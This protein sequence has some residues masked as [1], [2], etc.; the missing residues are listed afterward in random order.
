MVSTNNLQNMMTAPMRRVR[1]IHM[2]GIGG[3]GMAGIAE[4]LLNLGYEVSGTD[5]KESAATERL[6][7]LGAK[8]YF[9]HRAE[10]AHNVDAVVVSTAVKA[11]NPELEYA[12]VNFPS[13]IMFVMRHD[14]RGKTEEPI[15]TPS[16]A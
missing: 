12:R 5:L 3:S 4:V 7:E 10:N 6:T 15:H 2:L 14:M 1:R 16:S 8:I 9:G 13:S 11:G